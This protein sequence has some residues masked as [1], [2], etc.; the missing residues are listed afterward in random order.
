[1]RKFRH[2]KLLISSLAI[3]LFITF[4]TGYYSLVH[5][6]RLWSCSAVICYEKFVTNYE[7][8]Y[9]FPFTTI[10][11]TTDVIEGLENE[12]QSDGNKS[13]SGVGYQA[14]TN[15]LLARYYHFIPGERAQDFHFFGFAADVII[16]STMAAGAIW[17][18]QRFRPKTKVHKETS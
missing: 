10:S 3:G 1:M 11:Y 15:Y 7:H 18:I 12:I 4:L 17:L 6:Q 13:I 9:G 16:Y 5:Y 8:T 14:Q 2:K